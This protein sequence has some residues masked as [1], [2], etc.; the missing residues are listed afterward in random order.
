MKELQ[1][2][3]LLIDFEPHVSELGRV[4][5]QRLREP[6]DVSDVIQEV[7][8]KLLTLPSA[9]SIRHPRAFL[10]RIGMNLAMDRLRRHSAHVR[11]H[12]ELDEDNDQLALL[13]TQEVT[14]QARQQLQ[15]LN[16]AINELPPKC[17]RAFVLH[18]LKYWPHKEIAQHMG[19]S[20]NMVERHVMKGLSHCRGRLNSAT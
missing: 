5:S 12:A 18:K 6:S 20:Q 2:T 19:I 17:R 3:N 15:L 11:R 9:L 10:F 13:P 1:Q 8:L 16:Q 4:L 14:L 7:W